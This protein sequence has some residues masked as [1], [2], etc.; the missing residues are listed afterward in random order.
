MTTVAPGAVACTCAS[1]SG[2][3]S[4]AVTRCPDRDESPCQLAGAGAQIDD[5]ERLLPR[6]PAH[7]VGGVARASALVCIGDAGERDGAPAPLVTV[8]DHAQRIS[9][10]FP[11]MP[12]RRGATSSTLS[13]AQSAMSASSS[14]PWLIRL[15]PLRDWRKRLLGRRVRAGQPQRRFRRVAALAAEALDDASCDVAV[16][17]CERALDAGTEDRHV[18]AVGSRGLGHCC[19]VEQ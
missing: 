8:D 12:A 18:V 3:G 19:E 4:T 14:G 17:Q 5:V 9:A 1:I 15:R 13:R 7:R 2:S 6:E 16:V 10:A 11:C